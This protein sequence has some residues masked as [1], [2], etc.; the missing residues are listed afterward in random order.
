MASNAGFFGRLGN[1]WRGFLSL[2]IGSREAENPEAVYEAAINDRVRQYQDLK[3]AVSNI[4]YLRNNLQKD[5]EVKSRELRDVAAQLP[6]AVDSGDDEVAL[7]LIQKKDQLQGQIEQIKTDL[8]KVSGQADDAKGALLSFQAEI[9]KLKREKDEMVARKE[10]AQARVK[11]QESLSGLS[12]EADIK[13]LENVRESVA[14][15][16]AEADINKELGETS[17][18]ARLARVRS[19]TASASAQAQLDALK[20]ARNQD[21]EGGGGAAAASQATVKK[22]L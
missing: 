20:A 8:E 1:L 3:K 4:I 10:T 11:I 2:W 6:V 15:L 14:K 19:K 13:A 18:D 22:T 7:V 5:L 12:T 9:D 21:R 16:E 17:L